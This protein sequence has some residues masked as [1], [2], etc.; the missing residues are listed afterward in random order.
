MPIYDFKCSECGKEQ[1]IFR[2]MADEQETTI[3]ECIYCGGEAH[4]VWTS[5]GGPELFTPYYTEALSTGPPVYVA[6]KK[7]EKA[8]EKKTGFRRVG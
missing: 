7:Q 3:T 1:E 2:N 5:V 4:R 8:I 6:D